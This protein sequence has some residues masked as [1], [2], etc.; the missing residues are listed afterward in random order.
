MIEFFTRYLSQ[1]VDSFCYAVGF[2]L[3][4][5]KLDFHHYFG[6]A[7]NLE[8]FPPDEEDKISNT[9]KGLF[10]VKVDLLKYPSKK[11]I[12]KEVLEHINKKKE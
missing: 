10:L 2:T 5:K 9:D 1:V 4:G 7:E 12:L 3:S 11:V 6:G 8:F